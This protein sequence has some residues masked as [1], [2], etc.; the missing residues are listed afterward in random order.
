MCFHRFNVNF[1]GVT[2]PFNSSTKT[3]SAHLTT[4][5]WIDGFDSELSST[6]TY[7][8]QS[9]QTHPQSHPRT[10]PPTSF[11]SPQPT[12]LS[13]PMATSNVYPHVH[14][15]Y[16][17]MYSFLVAHVPLH[18]QPHVSPI[19]YFQLLV[20]PPQISPSHATPTFVAT[21]SVSSSHQTHTLQANIAC[22]SPV[23][24]A[25]SCWFPD[26][27]A[28]NHLTN[29]L[30]NPQVTT[31]YSGSSKVFVGNG[32]SLHISATGSSLVPTH[33]INL[34]LSNM[35][36]T[37]CVTK[38]L[39]FVSQSSKDNNVFF[40]FHDTHCLVKN[41]VS[42][43]VLL[44][45]L[46]PGGLYKLDLSSFPIFDTMNT[47]PCNS[48]I[49]DSHVSL[50][51]AMDSNIG[52][53]YELDSLETLN[54]PYDDLGHVMDKHD[55]FCFISSLNSKDPFKLWHMRLG[56][57]STNMLPN[58]LRLQNLP[59]KHV[60]CDCVACAVGKSKMLPHS[61]S[62]TVYTS[63][64]E[65]VQINL[66]RPSPYTSSNNNFYLSIV[67]AHSRYTW[68]YFL[69]RKSDAD[70]AFH[71]FHKLAKKQLGHQLKAIQ[72]DS[73]GEFQFLSTYL[74]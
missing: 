24:Q 45:V 62:N 4:M 58:F 5:N 67:D 23:V 56:H 41:S 33:N 47:M 55:F 42:H 32:S 28:N 73:G 39:L 48:N 63:P 27:G 30:P 52:H 50:A 53:V 25:Y 10:Q 17:Y 13:P 16:P 69:H 3:L 6:S 61:S 21:S 71:D 14:P 9:M 26:S 1:T 19:P 60:S 65:F 44:K 15:L 18:V 51:L 72:S 54:S 35:L 11:P 43:R 46:E 57:P 8:Q 20:L 74:P 59:T 49:I 34:Q 38:N 40:E 37:H 64:L 2:N 22:V 66:W 70:A 68:I 36:Y 7:Q 29:A 12:I 31:T